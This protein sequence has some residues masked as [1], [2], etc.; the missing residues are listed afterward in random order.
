ML[1]V[2]AQRDATL[3]W[4]WN[5]VATQAEKDE[6]ERL[7]KEKSKENTFVADDGRIPDEPKTAADPAPAGIAAA[8]AAGAATVPVAG[9]VVAGG[10][11]AGAAVAPVKSRVFSY[12]PSLKDMCMDLPSFDSGGGDIGMAEKRKLMDAGLCDPEKEPEAKRWHGTHFL[13]QGATGSCTH[14][15]LVDENQNIDQVSTDLPSPSPYP[16]TS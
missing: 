11:G 2:V 16:L 14:W 9:T 10:A 5:H 3:R 15:V 7:L 13:G 4:M 8:A 1:F 6:C 12:M